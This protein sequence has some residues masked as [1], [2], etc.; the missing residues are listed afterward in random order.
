MFEKGQ[1]GVQNLYYICE[2]TR[3]TN[4]HGSE[5]SGRRRAGPG[6]ANKIGGQREEACP[7]QIKRDWPKAGLGEDD[8]LCVR[9][10]SSAAD[11]AIQ[12]IK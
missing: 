3:A 5:D 9:Q 7:K 4:R 2:E 11:E 8:V 1:G 6:L 12:T 10:R